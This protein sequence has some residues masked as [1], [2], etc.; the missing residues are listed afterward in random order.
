MGG[1]F[2][3]VKE[4]EALRMSC[5]TLW[6]VGGWV[7]GLLY[8]GKGARGGVEVNGEEAVVGLVLALKGGGLGVRCP[9]IGKLI[10]A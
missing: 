10:P 7:G 9:G 6:V 1:W 2:S 8:L 3:W 5:W 4:D